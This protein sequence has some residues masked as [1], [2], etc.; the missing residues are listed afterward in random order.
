MWETEVHLLMAAFVKN[1][2]TFKSV[3]NALINKY[4]RTSVQQLRLEALERLRNG[5]P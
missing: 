1:R 3:E 2:K 5:H 4:G